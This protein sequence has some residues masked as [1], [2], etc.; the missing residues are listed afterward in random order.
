VSIWTPQGNKH[1][2]KIE[3]QIAEKQYELSRTENDKAHSL[4][5][6][7]TYKT[8]IRELEESFETLKRPGVTVSMNEYQEMKADLFFYKEKKA[9][10]QMYVDM[11]TTIILDLYKNIEELE[12]AREKAKTVIIEFSNELRKASK[13]S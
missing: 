12:K 3:I 8:K 13:R 6:F 4:L 7:H 9:D 1:Q 5:R 10:M 2:I 11:L